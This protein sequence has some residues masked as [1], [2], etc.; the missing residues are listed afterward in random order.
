VFQGVPDLYDPCNRTTLSMMALCTKSL[1][2]NPRRL[3][4]SSS[5]SASASWRVATDYGMYPTRSS[6]ERRS[7]E[8]LLS[9]CWGSTTPGPDY[10]CHGAAAWWHLHSCGDPNVIICSRCIGMGT[11]MLF[12]GTVVQ[13]TVTARP[14]TNCVAAAWATMDANNA[15]SRRQ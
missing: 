9:V 1:M 4:P 15:S 6:S 10:R 5:E 12:N 2:E 3:W 13:T 7:A 11:T 8:D 14:R